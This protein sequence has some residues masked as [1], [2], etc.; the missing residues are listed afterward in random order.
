LKPGRET[1]PAQVSLSIILIA[2]WL[3][4]REAE[5]IHWVEWPGIPGVLVPGA[6]PA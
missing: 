2:R 3:E 1:L 5:D 6:A 4:R